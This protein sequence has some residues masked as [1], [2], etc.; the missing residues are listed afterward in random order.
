[1]AEQ[2]DSSQERTEEPTAKRLKDARDKGQIPRSKELNTLAVVIVAALGLLML[3]PG[4]AQRLMDVMVYNFAFEREVLYVTDSMGW[5]LM[6]S[7]DQGLRSL[8][9]L[10]LMLLFAALGGPILLGGWLLSAKSMA[11]KFE[12]LNPI[13]GLKRMFSLKALVELLKALAKFLV[14]LTVALLV[15][16]LRREDM[17]SMANEPLPIAIVHAGWVLGTSLLLL[18]CSLI[19]IA[20]VDIPFQLWDNKKKLR[21]TKQEIKDEFKDTEGKP[22]VKSRIRQLQREMAER[23]M[24]SEVPKADVVITNPTHYAVALKYDP[25]KSGAPVLVAKGADFLAQKIREIAQEHDVVVLESP[26]L[27]RAVF[28]STELEQEIPA[29]LYLAVAQVLAYVFQLRQYR[30]GQGK[31]P[32]PMPEPKIPDDLRRDE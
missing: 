28:H 25:L 32:G 26:P 29:G 17:L 30:A 22:E 27:A 23:R 7:L 21:M 6:A 13:A 18:A 3:G 12:R 20:A 14:V 9:P 4:M 5:H 15:L 16:N 11:P 1:M 19:V 2:Q 24:M 10:F 31:R 8:G